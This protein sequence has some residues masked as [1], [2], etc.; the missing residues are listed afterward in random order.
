MDNIIQTPEGYGPA[1]NLAL[2]H[3]AGGLEIHDYMYNEEKDIWYVECTDSRTGWY[4][5][6]FELEGPF[7]RSC[8][9]AA[10]Q[11]INCWIK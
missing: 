1:I 3:P 8:F 4:V 11:G 5:A 10:N 6:A 9:K 2:N 7:V